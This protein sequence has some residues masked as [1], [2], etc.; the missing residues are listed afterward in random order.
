MSLQAGDLPQAMMSMRLRLVMRLGS[1][2]VAH[3]GTDPSF[4]VGFVLFEVNQR[5]S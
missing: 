5:I 1:W 2:S 3:T 4:W